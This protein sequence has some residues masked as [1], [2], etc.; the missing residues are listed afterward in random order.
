MKVLNNLSIKDLKLNKKR[1]LVI[2]IGI[3]LSTALICGVAGLITSFQ[4]TLIDYEKSSMGD[5]HV[6]F[7]N[8]PK[9]ELK[10]IEENREIEKY[11]LSENI[12][13]AK[14]ENSQNKNKPYLHIV[15]MDNGYLNNMGLHLLEGRLPENSSELVISKHIIS[16]GKVEL[17]VGDTITLEIGKRQTVTGEELNQNNPY[18]KGIGTE[19]RE[20]NKEIENEVVEEELVDTY[21]KTYTIVG[22]SERP[23]YLREGYEAPGYT[24]ITKMDTVQNKADISVLY[25]NLFKY[26]ENTE[27]IN[28]MVKK[29]K[30]EVLE[31]SPAIFQGMRNG[32][33]K[34]YKYEMEVNAQ[35]LAYEGANLSDGT[36]QLLYIVGGIVMTIILVTSIFVIRN[37]FAISVT[38]R[39]KQYGMLSSVGA[40]K[41]QIKKTVYFEGTILGVIGIPL[42]I[43]SGIF[44]IDILLKV[45]NKIITD[46]IEDELIIKYNISYI[47]I[48]ISVIIAV[49]TIWFSCKSSARKASKVTPIEAIR[50]TNDIKLKAKKIKCPRIISKIFKTGGE[51]AYKNLKRSRKKYRTTVISIIVSIV[52]FIAISSF[53]QYGFKMSTVYYTETGYNVGI[54]EM[55]HQ[56]D[57]PKEKIL[58]ETYNRFLEIAKLDGIDEYSIHRTNYIELDAT[59]YLTDFGKQTRAFEIGENGENVPL[60]T[61][62]IKSLGEQEYRN[63]IKKIG[64]KYED[65]KDGAI[66]IDE[67]MSYSGSDGKTVQGN[68]YNLKKGD[69]IKGKIG[70]LEETKNTKKVQEIKIVGKTSERPMGLQNVYSNSGYLIV[71][72]EYIEK[73][74]YI[75]L[76][77]MLINAKDSFKVQE[78]IEQ[79][80]KENKINDSDYIVSNVDEQT[81]ANNAVILIVSIFLYGFIAVIS[82]IGVTNIFNTITT[83]MNL[84]KKE[85]AMLKSIGMTKKEFNRMIRLESIFYGLKSLIIGI[86]IGVILSYL[87]YKAFGT[88]IEMSYILPTKAIIIAIVFVII[89]I[90]IIMK[91]SMRKINKQ[92]IIETIRNDN[93]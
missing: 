52:T 47:A 18:L 41:K 40:T 69:T 26:E 80:Y 54:Y 49:L 19:Y 55:S 66:L 28:E 35:L 10:Y 42:G 39:L 23:R 48:L 57:V 29:E 67:C 58:E 62:I 82:L 61:L 85:F 9:E 14:L 6:T 90:G 74:G 64:G 92:N 50:N 51:I 24:V 8:V 38:E 15:S 75:N 32:P 56:V 73:I 63:F 22:I 1:S 25:K 45:V 79:I 36:I 43:L 84:R 83:N 59:P 76:S 81:K 70:K 4:N 30:G 87:I 91:Y 11:Y 88:N 71:S 17:K 37:G 20:L 2:I 65:Y 16:N 7:Y 21:I 53:I 13:Y 5:Y 89:I 68:L 78:E 44:A 34:S 3:I 31:E 60:D 12:G 72:D 46:V 77:E 33:Y 93:I 86:P 27:L